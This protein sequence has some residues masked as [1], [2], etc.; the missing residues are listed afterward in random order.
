[1]PA[2]LAP[3]ALIA[4]APTPVPQAQALAYAGR[5]DE[6]Q[7]LLTPWVVA[8]PRDEDARFLL[9]RILAWRGHP[10][11]ALAQY[12]FLLA[13]APANA[14]YVL[15]KARAQ[16]ALGRYDDALALCARAVQLAPTYAEVWQLEL[17]ILERQGR[18]A[19]AKRLRA[20]LAQR[21]PGAA[22]LEGQKPGSLPWKVDAMAGL[23][24]L[25]NGYAPW[26]NLQVVVSRE[27]SKRQAGF[28]SVR[29]AG[30]F[31]LHDQEVG[32]GWYQP[33]TPRLTLNAEGTLS[34]GHQVLP[35]WA[36]AG[37]A[38]FQLDGG[39]GLAGELR[40]TAYTGANTTRQLLVADKY[41]GAWRTA[42]TLSLTE[43]PSAPVAPGAALTVEYE[44]GAGNR[45]GLTAN[46]GREMEFTGPSTLQ[47]FDVFGLAV[48]GRTWIGPRWGLT[49]AVGLAVQGAAYTRVGAQLGAFYA[50]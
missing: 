45:E 31:G 32:L 24:Y 37:G 5:L 29:D 28:L 15:G 46:A 20:Q 4:Q 10:E 50:F 18:Q 22:W 13:T 6:A 41:W 8:H 17:Q 12:D 27:P 21:F 42:A 49:H 43:L 48:T 26:S 3:P 11:D 44:Y 47:I 39:W 14:D 7:R 40:Q 36:L 38:Y 34:P 35:F 16:V 33:V 23:D 25:T 30:R 9:A 1:M 19:E 2:M